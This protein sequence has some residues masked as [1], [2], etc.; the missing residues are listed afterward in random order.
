[1]YKYN[2]HFMKD[3]FWLILFCIVMIRAFFSVNAFCQ[4]IDDYDNII[5]SLTNP[6]LSVLSTKDSLSFNFMDESYTIKKGDE[7]FIYLPILGNRDY[8][9][10]EKK[11]GFFNTKLL[12]DIVDIS[13]T[14]AA[15]VALGSNNVNTIIGA[16]DVMNKAGS[17]GYGLDALEKIESLNISS[18][19]K[20]IAGKKAKVLSW[21]LLD[22]NYMVYVKIEKKKYQINYVNAILA[23]EIKLI[24]PKM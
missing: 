1:M 24:K 18:S 17:V 22:D 4:E 8:L 9:F 15:A 14:G 6:K 11:K 10:I 20:K 12:K 7:L 5:D 2:L 21:K 13:R 16:L 23:K 19:A 3:T